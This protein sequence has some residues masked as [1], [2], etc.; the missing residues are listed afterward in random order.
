MSESGWDD[1]SAKVW[2]DHVLNEMAPNMRASAV[3]LSMVPTDGAGD[4]KYW[5]ELGASI[6]MD[7]PIIALVLG[8][9]SV[10]RKLLGIADEVVR[11][12]DG[13]NPE[14]SAELAAAISR[15]VGRLGD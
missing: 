1:P 2:V 11:L 12:P 15:V 4:V 9:A 10:P 6:M 13:V 7:K 5:V 8:G 3:V 14:G